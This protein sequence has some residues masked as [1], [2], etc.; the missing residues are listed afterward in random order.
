MKR[1]LVW[2]LPVR[3]G[4]WLMVG[5]FALAWATGDSEKWRLVHV[6]AGS[7]VMAVAA[8]RLLWGIVGSRTARFA[9]F[10]RGPGQAFAYLK[11]LLLARPPHYAGH[12]PAA[13]LAIVLLL[14]LALASGASGWL[15]YQEIGGE[16]LEEVHEFLTGLM[17]AVVGVHV[18]GVVVGSLAHRE[19][20][21]WAMV[22]G[23]KLGRPEEAI[24]GQRFVAALML[25]AWTAAAAWWLAR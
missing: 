7:T 13:G 4:H 11:S 20:L 24:A 17:L 12:N 25:L 9:E 21:V 19:N 3:L 6:F 2:D 5:G 18:L 14:G 8:Y 1:I 10:V 22:T 15:T 23:R 16:W